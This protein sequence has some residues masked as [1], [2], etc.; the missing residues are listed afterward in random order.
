MDQCKNDV[1]LEHI[2]NYSKHIDEFRTQANS[3]GI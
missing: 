2:K 1:I 3:Q